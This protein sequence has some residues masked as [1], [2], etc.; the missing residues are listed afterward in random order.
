MRYPNGQEVRDEM[1]AGA[2]TKYTQARIKAILRAVQ[3]G[4]PLIRAAQAG[5]IDR[6]TLRV[7]RADNP[8]FS[9]MVDEAIAK[10]EAYVL[11][12]LHKAQ[13]DGN[14]TA[15]LGWL[16]RRFPDD[17]SRGERLKQEVSGTLDVR[18]VVRGVQAAIDATVTDADTRRRLAEQLMALEPAEDEEGTNDG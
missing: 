3:L 18:Q 15:M 5:G 1:M 12:R 9:G 17:W 11:G 2:P 8:A 16:E 13:G 7:W 10:G 4:Q 6:E 14:V